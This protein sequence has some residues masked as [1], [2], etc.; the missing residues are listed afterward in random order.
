MDITFASLIEWMRERMCVCLFVRERETERKREWK[1]EL[2]K[3]I[4]EWNKN[5]DR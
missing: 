5:I 2:T 1:K 3:M 4:H